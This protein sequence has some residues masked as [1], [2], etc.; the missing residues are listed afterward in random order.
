MPGIITS[1][2]TKSGRFCLDQLERFCAVRGRVDLV[3]A[4]QDTDYETTKVGFV[5]GD[6]DPRKS[7]AVETAP[8]RAD[9]DSVASSTVASSMSLCAYRCESVLDAAPGMLARS[10]AGAV[11]GFPCENAL[12]R[13]QEE[14][15]CRPFAY[16]ALDGQ[17]S[18]MEL[19]ELASEREPDTHAAL[20]RRSEVSV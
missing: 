7:T 19:R 12:C 5:F 8:A 6:Q 15:E 17:G 16:D 3:V 2:S 9:V 20:T 1:V 14:R 11:P 13:L 4:L 10:G 18:T